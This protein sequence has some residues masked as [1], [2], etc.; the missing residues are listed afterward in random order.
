MKSKAMS[1]EEAES[2]I[3][4]LDEGLAEAERQMLRR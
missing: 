3:K 1:N 4:T 2:F